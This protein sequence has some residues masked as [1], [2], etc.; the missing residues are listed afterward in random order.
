MNACR[1]EKPNHGGLNDESPWLDWIQS[2]QDNGR[3]MRE[4]LEAADW[5]ALQ[6]AIRCRGELLNE[7]AG[8]LGAAPRNDPNSSRFGAD[9]DI[10]MA[11]RDA[12]NINGEIMGCLNSRRRDLKAKILEMSKGRKL[13]NLYKTHRQAAPRFFDRFG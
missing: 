3:L 5:E 13:L 8:R 12:L 2:L 7:A 6:Q 9:S 11:L 10:K 1:E 4:L